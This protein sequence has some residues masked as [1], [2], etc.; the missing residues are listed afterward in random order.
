MEAATISG[1]AGLDADGA[2]FT[3][4]LDPATARV[5]RVPLRAKNQL[6]LGSDAA[7]AQPTPIR[8]PRGASSSSSARMVTP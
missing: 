1:F 3:K 8:R 6:P 5:A 2:T 4:D 7:G